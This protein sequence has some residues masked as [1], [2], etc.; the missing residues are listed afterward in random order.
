MGT[1]S[2]RRSSAA[3]T[4]ALA[5]QDTAF[6]KCCLLSGRYDGANRNHFFPRIAEICTNLNQQQPIQQYAGTVLRMCWFE[7]AQWQSSPECFRG[8]SWVQIPPFIEF[9]AGRPARKR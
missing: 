5:A 2:F 7:V 8:W 6:K 1:R 4:L 3:M 9:E